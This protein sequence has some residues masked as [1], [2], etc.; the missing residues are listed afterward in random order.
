MY[1]N[2]KTNNHSFV[3]EA[4]NIK[5]QDLVSQY[6]K[7]HFKSDERIIFQEEVMYDTKYHLIVTV[8][9]YCNVFGTIKSHAFNEQDCVVIYP[10]Y[11]GKLNGVASILS[12]KVM[13]EIQSEIEK[14]VYF[15]SVKILNPDDVYGHCEEIITKL[16]VVAENTRSKFNMPVQK[17]ID[18]ELVKAQESLLIANSSINLLNLESVEYKKIIQKLQIKISD[19]DTK[20]ALQEEKI[21]EQSNKLHSHEI[22][23]TKQNYAS[24]ETANSH[25]ENLKLLNKNKI[26]ESDIIGLTD[27]N[28]TLKLNIVGQNEAIK[29]LN[30]SIEIKNK[31]LSQ[32]TLLLNQS[33]D[34]IMSLRANIVSKN[35]TIKEL[36]NRIETIKEVDDTIKKYEMQIGASGD[37]IQMLE[38]NIIGYA[39][40]NK[41][42][43]KIIIEHVKTIKKYEMQISAS[44]D[45]IQLQDDQIA[46]IESQNK[47]VVEQTQII[48]SLNDKIQV[49]TTKVGD[50][51]QTIFE[52]NGTITSKDKIIF[53]L[54]GTIT[55]KDKTIADKD[56]ELDS[57]NDLIDELKE[58]I[59]VKNVDF[60]GQIIT[61][62]TLNEKIQLLNTYLGD[63]DRAIDDL[64]DN[65][66]SKN[67][68][69]LDI[70]YAIKCRDNTIK[71]LK[72]NIVAQH[73]L[74]KL[75]E[76]TIQNSILI[77]DDV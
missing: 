37:S 11:A 14:T 30:D 31:S 6:T 17:T 16:L 61:I 51:M 26:L 55:S 28:K 2:N 7:F 71:E 64:D 57:Q 46:I 25:I 77:D 42:L 67:K 68:S 20:L 5:H 53:E 12:D 36:N 35:E 13:P 33:S 24:K 10:K 49:L 41:I 54:H 72:E 34:K 74:I 4:K 32:D 8:T 52:L 29:K 60:N 75:H 66:G 76:K 44:G 15:L 38:E 70:E 65:I 19:Q 39:D 27:E 1:S 62:K 23:L 59:I 21:I 45:S 40:E 50:M 73:E 58:N 18:P 9:N 22:R 69:I 56:Y 63:K 47:M 48:K 43:Q 3:M